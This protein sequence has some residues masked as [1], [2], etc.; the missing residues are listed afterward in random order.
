MSAITVE[1]ASRTYGTPVV[2]SADIRLYCEGAAVDYLDAPDG[3]SI[4][5][6][7]RMK[8]KRLLDCRGALPLRLLGPGTSG[9]GVMRQDLGH[10]NSGLVKPRWW[11]DAV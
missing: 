11:G 10:E 2:A 5:I 1:I 4:A 8:C 7:R 6:G 9:L 3:V